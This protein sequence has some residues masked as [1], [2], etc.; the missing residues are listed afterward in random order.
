M[1][2]LE[3]H[4]QVMTTS[5]I[6][7]PE[8]YP[9]V[10]VGDTEAAVE[11]LRSLMTPPNQHGL[12]VV[13]GKLQFEQF[14]NYGIRLEEALDALPD[15]VVVVLFRRD[16]IARHVSEQAATATGDWTA[17]KATGTSVAPLVDLEFDLIKAECE[18][19]QARY[20]RSISLLQELDH[21]H[22][23]VSYEELRDSPD[24]LFDSVVW[25]RLGLPPSSL[26]T[27]LVKQRTVPLDEAVSDETQLTKCLLEGWAHADFA[28][29]LDRFRFGL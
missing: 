4:A 23:L 11:H 19:S 8:I 26:K 22:I 29:S 28:T 25:D 20:S 7:H 5:E 2:Y 16:R 15:C 13:V 21:E 6:Y 10:K 18:R 27:D 1:S 14:E 12:K 24:H 17:K 3:S 9:D